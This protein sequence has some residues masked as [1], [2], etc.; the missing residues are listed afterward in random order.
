[1]LLELNRLFHVLGQLTVELLK[2]SLLAANV[3]PLCVLLRRNQ[4]RQYSACGALNMIK[5]GLIL[6]LAGY[7]Q[8]DV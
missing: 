4:F 7:A 2:D 8:S 5:H 1:M 3:G 6:V